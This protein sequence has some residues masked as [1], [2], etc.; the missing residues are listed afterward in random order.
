LG[1]PREERLAGNE[2]IFRVANERMSAWEE[3]HEDDAP[4]LYRCECANAA[5]Q[6]HVSLTRDEYEHV[7]E[8][9][10]HFVMVPG[11]EIP[12]VETV[13]ESHDGWAVVEKS[14]SVTPTVEAT[15]PRQ[16]GA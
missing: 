1:T 10:R 5:C 8:N 11:H 3:R 7:R 12:D 16:A 15:D 9:S 6:E 13:I 14:P 2:A 4:E